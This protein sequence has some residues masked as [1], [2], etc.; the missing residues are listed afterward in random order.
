MRSPDISPK[1]YEAYVICTSPRSGSTL[2]C[3]LLSATRHMG[4][5]DSHFHTPSVDRWLES[6]ALRREDFASDQ[7]AMGAIFAAALDRGRGGTD[8][9]GL[10]LQRGSFDFFMEKAAT[11]YPDA[12]SG[13]DHVE[14]AFG[15]TLFIHLTRPNKVDQA[16]SRVKAAQTG[17][18]HKAQDGR[19]LERSSGPQD[20]FYDAAAISEHVAELTAM[21]VAWRDWFDCEGVAPL[22]ISYDDLSR[23]PTSALRSVLGAFGADEALAAGIDA[24][25]A[26]LADDTSRRWAERFL[27]EPPDVRQTLD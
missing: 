17:L 11:L 25:T 19:E 10:R 27:A 5:P 1:R 4:A 21:D 18:W 22:R 15:P 8:V 3:G 9:F 13:V 7:E 24:P 12:Q 23:D 6:Y 26:K 20:P 16:I 14:A 2:L